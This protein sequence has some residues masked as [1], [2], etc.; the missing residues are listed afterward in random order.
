MVGCVRQRAALARDDVRY[1]FASRRKRHRL[2]VMMQMD[3]AA[4]R[5]G[6]LVWP[7]SIETFTREHWQKSVFVSH[8]PVDR[9][10]WLSGH[11]ALVD[12]DTMLAKAKPPI[13]VLFEAAGRART[14]SEPVDQAR[15]LYDA[16]MTLYMMSL[17]LPDI[18]G[19]VDALATLLGCRER[20]FAVS[21]FACRRAG[22]SRVHFDASENF[23]FQL[24]G[25]KTWHVSRRPFVESP[26]TNWVSGEPASPELR[27]LCPRPLAREMPE[28]SVRYDLMPGSML[29]LPSGHLHCT[30]ASEDSLSLTLNYGSDASTSWATLLTRIVG[31]ILLRNTMGRTQTGAAWD[32]KVTPSDREKCD[33][34]L[35]FLRKALTTVDSAAVFGPEDENGGELNPTARFRRQPLIYAAVLG[36]A[37]DDPGMFQVE[38]GPAGSVYRETITVPE[39]WVRVIEWVLQQDA[40]Q[41]EDIGKAFRELTAADST[42]VLEILRGIGAIRA[43]D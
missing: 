25:S 11:P 28:D 24:S 2:A 17:E 19:V 14:L 36:H 41:A 23:T 38:L 20:G 43:L 31:G 27:W 26:P 18:Q 8:G 30:S 39:A 32:G 22:G 3:E 4:K 21:S 16:G 40:F 10:S 42:H 33:R 1:S 29:Y 12:V 15:R 9:I 7:L 5:A 13:A 34:L 37:P 6:E 35:L